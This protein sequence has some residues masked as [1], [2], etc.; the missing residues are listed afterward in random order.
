MTWNASLAL[1]YTRHADKTVAHFRH[2]GPL[3]ILQSLYPEGEAICHNVIVHPPGGLVGGD[4]L[5]LA[6]TVGAGAHGLVTTP[7]ATR[8]YRSQGE[9]ALQRT[10]ITLD[11]GARMEWLPLETIAYSGCLA[12]NRL[13]LQLAPSAELMGWDVTALGLPAAGQPFAQGH[14]SQHIEVPG[15]WLERARIKA[16]DTLLLDSP[17][18]MAGHRCMASLFF[19]AGSKLERQRR[20]Q[21]LDA[22]RQVIEA[23]GLSA[24]AGATSP[25][26]QIVV[27]RVLAPMV[28]P[29]MDLLKQVWR[30]WRGHFWHQAAPSPRIWSV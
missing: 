19:V 16:T 3:R 21:A 8:F 29:A 10:R 11:A 2:D 17:L 15:V 13:T 1:D 30:V 5:D 9:P 18:G 20:E 4:T 6:F 23:H 12:E 25:D 22:A 24:T 26:G 7:G 28:E 27:V 14:F